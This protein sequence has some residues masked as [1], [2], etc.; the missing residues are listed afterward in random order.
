MTWAKKW[1]ETP[2][3]RGSGLG[4]FDIDVER[5][6]LTSAACREVLES[7]LAIHWGFGGWDDVVGLAVEQVDRDG[8]G[9]EVS[10]RR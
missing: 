9:L 6:G 3:V 5:I 2:L 8:E 7:S 10:M 1:D 4:A